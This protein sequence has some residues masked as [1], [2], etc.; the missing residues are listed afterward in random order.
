MDSTFIIWIGLGLATLLVTLLVMS[1]KRAKSILQNWA[2]D[3]GFHIVS[4]EKR[5]LIATGPFRWW[6]NSR[7]QVVY[8]IQVRD[9]EGTQRSG[10]L[11]CG[12]FFGGVLGSRKAEVRWDD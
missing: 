12:S 7:G 3:N 4:F 1:A 11:R 6:T 2:H 5:Y 10:W 9:R 8:F